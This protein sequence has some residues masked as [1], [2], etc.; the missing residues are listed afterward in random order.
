MDIDKKYTHQVHLKY[1]SVSLNTLVRRKKKKFQIFLVSEFVS[2]PE[3]KQ[4]TTEDNAFLTKK[5]HFVLLSMFR[6]CH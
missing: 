2:F 5:I 1:K 3:T 4:L 6:K